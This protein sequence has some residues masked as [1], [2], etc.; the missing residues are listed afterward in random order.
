MGGLLVVTFAGAGQGIERFE[1]RF[2]RSARECQADS[3][4]ERGLAARVGRRRLCFAS[5]S[6]E[7]AKSIK[8]CVLLRKKKVRV[9]PVDADYV[10]FDIEDEFVVGYGLDFQEK[11]RN[12][13]CIGVLHPKVVKIG[14]AAAL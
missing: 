13:P 10:G 6:L 8:T 3:K 4:S 7:R 2:I 11:Y 9:K 5:R 12:L 1:E 14:L